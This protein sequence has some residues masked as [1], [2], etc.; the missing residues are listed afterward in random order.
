MQ[1]TTAQITR[2]SFALAAALIALMLLGAPGARAAG[3]AGAVTTATGDGPAAV[4]DYWTLSRMRAAT[5]AQEPPAEAI[6]ARPDPTSARVASAEA[7]YVPAAGPDGGPTAIRSGSPATPARQDATGAAGRRAFT[8]EEI[9]DPS[10]AQVRM[11][12]KVFFTIPEGPEAGDYVCSGTALNSRNRSVVWT[13]GHCVFD[14]DGGGFATNWVFVPAYSA[15]GAPFGEWPARRLATTKG[16]KRSASIRY[17]L[18]AAVVASDT[19]G[20]RL[21]DVVG[22]RGIAFDQPRDQRY[23]AYGYPAEGNPAEFTG[24]REY[25]CISLM[26]GADSPLGSGPATLGIDCDMSGGASGG[27]WISGSTLLSVT[28]Y[29]YVNEPNRLYGPY[30]S[31]GAKAL[32]R[33]AA[34]IKKKPKK[35]KGG[36]GGTGR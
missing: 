29:G 6:G 1:L 23:L 2:A 26:T 36:K 22:G 34:G 33:A 21:G 5:D 25:R 12:G 3:G 7:S 15:A 17:D 32:Y 4:R 11:H 35:S 14:T 10:A 13:A 16:W 24:A 19:S 9:T 31:K 18:G 8:R 30:L 28:S 27:G 20:R